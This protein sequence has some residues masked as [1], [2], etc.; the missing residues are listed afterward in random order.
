MLSATGWLLR[1][2]FYEI[3]PKLVV[4][5]NVENVENVEHLGNLKIVTVK[6]TADLDTSLEKNSQGQA[7]SRMLFYP[8]PKADLLSPTFLGTQVVV[9][10]SWYD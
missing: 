10:R 6:L 2:V 1:L 7:D 8:P 5:E 4:V 3:N 9:A